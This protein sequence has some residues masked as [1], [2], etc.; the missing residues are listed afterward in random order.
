MRSRLKIALSAAL[1]LPFLDFAVLPT[2]ARTS[3]EDHNTACNFILPIDGYI[4]RRDAEKIA[5]EPPAATPVSAVG[6][7]PPGNG[8][9]VIDNDEEGALEVNETAQ[10]QEIPDEQGKTRVT[11]GARF[12]ISIMSEISSKSARSGDPIQA[13]TKVDLKIGGKLIAAKGT[14]VTGHVTNVE[15]ARALLHSEFSAKRWMRANG[16][17]GLQFDE[18]VTDAGEHLPLVATPARQARIVKNKHEGRV[19]GVNDRGE[20]AT[21]LSIQLKCQAAHLAIR[22]AASAG[23]VFSFGIIPVAY[24]TVGAIYPAFAFGH[25][26]GQSVR[27]RRLKGFGLGVLTGLPGGFLIADSIVHGQETVIKPGDEFLVEFKQDFTGEAGTS[28]ELIP[29]ATKKVHGELIKEKK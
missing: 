9:I 26:V 12:P 22:S 1:I 29:G 25:P 20:V 2:L 11:T 6:L 10:W 8:P 27:H 13:R 4:G 3:G 15:R 7:L 17:V 21:P 16:A 19:L 23:G 14:L 24:G 18:I 28:A 5:R